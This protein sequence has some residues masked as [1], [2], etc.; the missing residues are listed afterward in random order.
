[1]SI[2]VVIPTF[3]RA[4]VISRALDSVL[5]QTYAAD[6]IIVVDDGSNDGTV[7]LVT[8]KYPDVNLIQL[9]KNHGVSHARNCGINSAGSEWIALL[10]SDDEWQAD[11]LAAQIKA[12]KKEPECKICHS[13]EI[14]IRNDRHLN[15]KKKHAKRGGWI[16]QN[17]LPLCAISPSA[18]VIHRS[19]FED[20]GVFDETLPAC[21]DYDLWLRIT[22]KYPVLFIP[23]PLVIKH[24]GHDDQLSKKHWG[25]DRF[26]IQALEKAVNH[27]DL[28]EKDHTAALRMLVEKLNVIVQGAVKR[29]NETVQHCYG[30]KLSH[31]QRLLNNTSA[32][33][34]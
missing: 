18:A 8:Q 20:V 2:A 14:W 22:A 33:A 29:N 4:H 12:L 19:V 6:E 1:M 13:D 21:E 24:G 3:N 17:C 28:A 30:M 32:K 34:L 7:P 23:A 15:Q 31:Y 5:R 10:D 26:R 11:K 9:N 27:G 25:M 16:F